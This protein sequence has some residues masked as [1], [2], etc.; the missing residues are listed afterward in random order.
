V[1][2]APAA[3]LRKK[4]VPPGSAEPAAATAQPPDQAKQPTLK[5]K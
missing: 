1:K 2:A 5:Q 4:P 3:P